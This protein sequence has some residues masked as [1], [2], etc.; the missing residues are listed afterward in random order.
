MAHID[1]GK[2]PAESQAILKRVMQQVVDDLY[3][4]GQKGLISRVE[5]FMTQHE[6]TDRERRRQH[7]SNT[8][9]LNI[10]IGLLIAIAA[11]I[12][13]VVSLSPFK[14]SEV[15]PHKVFHTENEQIVAEYHATQ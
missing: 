13:I 10:I 2:T 6:A 15:D 4:N 11:Y 5:E 8:A 12:A 9:R 3:D 14:K 7:E 1:W